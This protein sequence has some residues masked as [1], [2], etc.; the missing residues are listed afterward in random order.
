MYAYD[1]KQL[2]KN[3]DWRHSYLRS[4]PHCNA[5]FYKVFET[6]KSKRNIFE[7]MARCANTHVAYG[8]RE[9]KSQVNYSSFIIEPG[10]SCS[11]VSK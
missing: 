7:E 8:E 10:I 3:T 4:T 6:G 2:K 1:V 9:R 5:L 11:L